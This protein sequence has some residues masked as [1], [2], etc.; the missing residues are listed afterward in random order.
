MDKIELT[1][2]VMKTGNYA[3]FC[4]VSRLHL[5][6]SNPVGYIPANG[7]TSYILRGLKSKSILDRKGAINLETGELNTKTTQTETVNN[8]VKSEA[9]TTTQTDDTQSQEAE[10]VADTKPKRNSK[11]SADTQ[12]QE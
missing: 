2:N 5:T 6:L 11:K 7:V 10:V 8:T 1:L 9:A 12:T 3:F 4:P